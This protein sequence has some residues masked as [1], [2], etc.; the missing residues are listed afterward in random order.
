MKK[1]S[2]LF[3]ALVLLVLTLTLASCAGDCDHKWNSGVMSAT[4]CTEPG[5]ITY[6]CQKCGET[7][8]LATEAK[9]HDYDE[10]QRMIIPATCTEDGFEQNTCLRCNEVITEVLAKKGH[11]ISNPVE[12]PPTCSSDGSRSG[13]CSLCSQNATEVIP[14]I[15]HNFSILKSSKAATC[16]TGG[17]K[18][19]KCAYCTATNDVITQP[20]GVHKYYDDDAHVMIKTAPTETT[21]GEKVLVC[22]TCPLEKSSVYTL[23]EY[24][25]DLR[26][27]KNELEKFDSSKLGTGSITTMNPDTYANPTA[28][29]TAGE[30]PRLLINTTTLNDIRAAIL[31]PENAGYYNDIIEAAN[32]YSSGILGEVTKHETSPKGEHN[33]NE[34]LYNCLMSKALLYLLTGV[35][36]YAYDALRMTKEFMSTIKIVTVNPDPERNWGYAM[37]TAAI[38]YDWCYSAMS[39]QDKIDIM[40][41]IEYCLCKSK[42]YLGNYQNNMEVGFPPSGQGAVCGHGSERQI[43]RDYLSVA[44]AIYDEE[45]SWYD[46][47]GGRF[48]QEYVP[49]RNEFYKSGMYPQGISV[50]IQIRFTADLWS[51]WLMQ[52]A[53]GKNPYSD[54]MARVVPSLFS[55]IVNGDY[56][57]FDEGDCEAKPDEEIVNSFCFAA[58]ISA[59]LYNDSVAASLSNH[60]GNRYTGALNLLILKSTQ[61]DENR[62]HFDGLDLICYNGGFMN[63][64]VAHSDWGTSATSVLMKIGGRSTA[65][66]DHGD[67]GSFQIYYKG[68]LAGDTGFY[69]TYN[70][71]HFKDYHQA[72][73]AHNSVVIYRNEKIVGK[74]KAG[75]SY[76]EPK[77]YSQWMTDTYKTATLKGV[78]YGYT[79][80]EKT[81]PTYAYIAGDIA[82][83]YQ[84]SITKGDRR[85][86]AVFDTQSTDASLY[87]FVYDNFV[88][89]NNSDMATF[90][91]HTKGVPSITGNTVSV[92]T[93]GGKLVLQNIIGGDKIVAI[94]GTNKNYIVNGTQVATKNDEDDGYWGRVEISSVNGT[95]N[96]TMLN[97]MYVTDATNKASIKATKISGDKVAGSVIGNTAAVFVEESWK[98]DK[99]FSFTT[100][101]S[102]D[103]NYYVSGVKAGNWTVTVG[104]TTLTVTATEEG[105]L[106]T[107][108]AP[109]G[110]VTV[111]PAG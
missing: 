82:P 9:G 100:T 53:T 37:F 32:A 72:T 47:I 4:S 16:V 25:N 40:R 38:V 5:V 29:P 54:D 51:A 102:T 85:M 71:T 107:F 68:I 95:K 42:N 64:I 7:K 86:L 81:A 39:D 59:Y 88:G 8:E 62:P 74:Q 10:S 69:D 3:M 23:E 55:R 110:T 84:G 33:L 28:Y 17:V 93:G 27:A 99:A 92:S 12:V 65:N 36:T 24:Q 60:Y 98:Y 20:T 41:G 56:I 46:F 6:T 26:A 111:T 50:Y 104:S 75:S 70:S 31:R 83:A 34:D 73:I 22:K 48:F 61:V 106:L 108:T 49:V 103:L 45:P 76:T 94:G 67:A 30:H 97:V 58:S 13:F 1:I 18:T 57:I 96:D 101:G 66:H 44:L 79:D 21:P 35:K 87:F 15:D 2:L 77:T 91:L 52:S 105:G 43:L 19:Y 80:A 11:S 90:L 14:A 78:S 63:E 109:A 89:T